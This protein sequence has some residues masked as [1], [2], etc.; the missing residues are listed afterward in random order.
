M[1]I[2]LV[3]TFRETRMHSKALCNN[4]GLNSGFASYCMLNAQHQAKRHCRRTVVF[5]NGF[6][7]R[8]IFTVG[9]VGTSRIN[10]GLR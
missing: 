5:S 4:I 1:R 9:L 2:L 10:A 8:N 3:V 6:P 7:Y